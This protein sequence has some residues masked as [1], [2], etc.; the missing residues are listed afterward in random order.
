MKKDITPNPTIWINKQHKMR[1]QTI[2]ISYN[3]YLEC[4]QTIL[5]TSYILGEYSNG[6]PYIDTLVFYAYDDIALDIIYQSY[7]LGTLLKDHVIKLEV[8]ELT[9]MQKT[10][11]QPK[12][13]SKTE[14]ISYKLADPEEIY[15][16]DWDNMMQMLDKHFR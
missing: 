3:T 11:K 14:I 6:K 4:W 12:I 5:H 2:K 8:E 9:A 16:V 10:I 1:I 13:H 15:E 7:M